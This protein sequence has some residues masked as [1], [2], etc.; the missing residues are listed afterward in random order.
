MSIDAIKEKLPEA[1]KDL[2]I[3]LATVLATETLTPDQRWG[4]V[5]ACAIATRNHGLRDALFAEARAQGVREE[6]LDDARGAAVMMA[7]NNVAY[8]GRHYLGADYEPRP[9]RLRM[10]RIG[11]PKTT[12]V[13]FE[14][15]CLAVSAIGG[16]QVCLSAHER[17]VREGGLSAEAVFDALR[18]AAVVQGVAVGLELGD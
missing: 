5:L 1:A 8:R 11:Q 2:R 4:V 16:C 15:M 18:I 7:M 12:K 9:L 13:D 3:N 10:H 6:V 14:L 17:V